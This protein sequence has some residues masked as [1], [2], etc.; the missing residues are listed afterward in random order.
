VATAT[1]IGGGGGGSGGGGFGDSGRG[2]CLQA[3][4][5]TKQG[6]LLDHFF[7][8]S[9]D[10]KVISFLSRKSGDKKCILH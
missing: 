7:L 3:S 4:P 10:S 1:A 9:F 8:T 5:A 2:D 6:I